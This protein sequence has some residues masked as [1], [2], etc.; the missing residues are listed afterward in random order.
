LQSGTQIRLVE[1]ACF[2]DAAPAD[3]VDIDRWSEAPGAL[4]FAAF[5]GDRSGCLPFG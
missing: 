4:A 5:E 1:G 2:V 3:V